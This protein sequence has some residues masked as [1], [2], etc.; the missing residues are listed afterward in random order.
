MA[1]TRARGWAA[2]AGRYIASTHQLVP[3]MP[4]EMDTSSVI[5]LLPF[6]IGVGCGGRHRALLGR[7]PRS[8]S[9]VTSHSRPRSGGARLT[10]MIR[11]P[12][13]ETGA[14]AVTDDK[15]AESVAQEHSLVARGR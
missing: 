11:K 7:R 9:H 14:C 8:P 3:T 2:R 10:P 6:Q 12:N 5:P 13:T 1:A 4:T 15:A